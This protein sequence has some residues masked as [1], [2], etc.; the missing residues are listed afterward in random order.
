M[1]K[2]LSFLKV[3]KYRLILLGFFILVGLLTGIFTAIKYCDGY[4]AINFN[5]YLLTQF[6]K[7]KIGTFDLFLE[8][9]LSYSC[10]CLILLV[11]SLA[12]FL[13]PVGLFVI[14]FRTY[15]LGLNITLIILMYGFG[16]IFN[17]VII[18]FPLQL[19][20]IL[21]ASIFFCIVRNRCINKKK[22]GKI[23]G[24]NSFYT[25]LIFILILTIINLIETLL[26]I[27]FSAQLILVI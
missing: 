25:F 27:L 23:Y 3:N 21:L 14:V 11:C 20:I 1:R 7:G 5:D 4:D 22:F 18:I 8:R 16:G 19:S 26:L 12:G 15:L 10:F 24:I 9:L 17:A 13:F 6:S 2:I